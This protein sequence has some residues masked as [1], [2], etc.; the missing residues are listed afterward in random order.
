[1]GG[2]GFRV[3]VWITWTM[4]TTKFFTNSVLNIQHSDSIQHSFVLSD[5]FICV[6]EGTDIIFCSFHL[7]N[8]LQEFL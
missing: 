7:G 2:I 4:F 6:L 5:S 8:R 1:M 3:V